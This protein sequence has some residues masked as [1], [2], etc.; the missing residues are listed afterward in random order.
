V[1]VT[2]PSSTGERKAARLRGER[3]LLMA[4]VAELAAERSMAAQ[5]ETRASEERAAEVL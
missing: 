1:E 3:A 4:A 5:R 2:R